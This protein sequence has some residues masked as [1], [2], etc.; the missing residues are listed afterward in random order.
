M[1]EVEAGEVE[2][3]GEVELGQCSI[4]RCM[5]SIELGTTREVYLGDCSG[6]V[7]DN[8]CPVAKVVEIGEGP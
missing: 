6:S 5:C 2:E 7:A 4:E 3:W 8:V 1:A